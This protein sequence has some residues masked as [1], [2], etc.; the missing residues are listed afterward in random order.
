M[1]EE[2]SPAL[3]LG[4]VIGVALLAAAMA[5]LYNSQR[6]QPMGFNLDY[7]PWVPVTSWNLGYAIALLVLVGVGCEVLLRLAE[8]RPLHWPTY[9]AVAVMLVLLVAVNLVTYSEPEVVGQKDVPTRLENGEL[10]LMAQPVAKTLP[11][12]GFPLNALGY[13][14]AVL[15]EDIDI[16]LN[17][18]RRPLMA[19][20]DYAALLVNVCIQLGLLALVAGCIE[21]RLLLAEAHRKADEHVRELLKA[22]RTSGEPGMTIVSEPVPE[23]EPLKPRPSRPLRLRIN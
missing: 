9:P 14:P 8:E 5:I 17:P 21:R 6:V 20:W 4:T 13:T 18:M 11:V 22:I 1:P 16:T 15:R 19:Y 7:L 3:H 12:N 10:V 2:R 23:K